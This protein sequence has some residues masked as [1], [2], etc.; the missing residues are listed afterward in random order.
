MDVEAFCPSPD[1]TV[2]ERRAMHPKAVD[3][4]APSTDHTSREA[5]RSPI[6]LGRSRVPE[7]EEMSSGAQGSQ[8][9]FPA[10]PQLRDMPYSRHGM[11]QTQSACVTYRDNFGMWCAPERKERWRRHWMDGEG[12]ERMQTVSAWATGNAIRSE[13]LYAACTE[14]GSLRREQGQGHGRER[15]LSPSAGGPES[16]SER[17]DSH[18]SPRTVAT[19]MKGCSRRCCSEVPPCAPSLLAAEGC[20][21]S[22]KKF[23]MRPVSGSG[24]PVQCIVYRNRA[25]TNR[26]HPSFTLFFQESAGGKEV[27]MLQAKKRLGNTTPNYWIGL[28]ESSLDKSSAAYLGKVRANFRGTEFSIYDSGVSPRRGGHSPLVRSELGAVTY[29]SL[30]RRQKSTGTVQVLLPRVNEWDRIRPW[31]ARRTANDMISLAKKKAEHGFIALV[32][33]LPEV[34]DAVGGF[35][36]DF[37]GRF[38]R[39]S[40]KNIQLVPPD[41][42]E[43]V[44]LQVGRVGR[45][46][47]SLDIKWPLSPFQAFA[48][49][50]TA[51]A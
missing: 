38:A 48:I 33:K 1:W 14:N 23:C 15:D 32:N 46:A 26:V 21:Q 19:P 51:L 3:S 30:S 13:D 35:A 45:D 34:E 42:Q 43:N 31:R 44:V 24:G 7:Y 18:G 25:G 11:I 12:Y 16:S 29:S 37:R 4:R 6:A 50:L 47:F 27:P 36:L 10:V 39:S 41:D 17:H 20:V 5:S 22:R 9:N 28:G 2:R 8:H 49:A 40:L